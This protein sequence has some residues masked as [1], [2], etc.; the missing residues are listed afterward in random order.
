LKT[1][2]RFSVGL[3]K[4]RPEGWN[5]RESARCKIS[6]ANGADF[7]EARDWPSTSFPG[8]K[9]D[10]ARRTPAGFACLKGAC[11]SGQSP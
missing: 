5:R 9:S 1:T 10:A 3:N 8:F 6:L 11:L 2:H 7:G 4:T